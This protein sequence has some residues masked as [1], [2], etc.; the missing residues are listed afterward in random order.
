MDIKN[1][2]QMKKSLFLGSIASLLILLHS[3]CPTCENVLCNQTPLYAKGFNL[4]NLITILNPKDTFDLND[5][6]WMR[7]ELPASFYGEKKSCSYSSAVLE[8][9][10]DV[11]TFY[12]SKQYNS[13][14]PVFNIVPR[15]GSYD[16]YPNGYY[17]FSL[18][19]D[20]YIA[21]FGVLLNDKDLIGIGRDTINGDEFDKLY[22]IRLSDHGDSG[23]TYDDDDCAV[24]KKR[25]PYE[26]GFYINTS[27]Q[28]GVQY[29]KINMR[30]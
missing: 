14:I 7:I 29:W 28:G 1:S 17:N 25:H 21:E 15:I 19:N 24:G 10:P 18:L 5:T 3:C 9:A 6:L 12:N 2:K 4:P 26:R 8:I 27:F 11:F 22:G 20:S 16:G 13:M 23:C 30:Q